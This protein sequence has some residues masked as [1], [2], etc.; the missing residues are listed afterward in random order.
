MQGIVVDLQAGLQAAGP[1]RHH[2]DRQAVGVDLPPDFPE[3]R[4]VLLPDGALDAQKIARFEV[5][6]Q[7]VT[8]EIVGT[9]PFPGT[10]AQVFV[11][12]ADGG[13]GG[14]PHPR[15]LAG[16]VV[17]R[18]RLQGE[19]A[20]QVGRRNPNALH[21]R[22]GAVVGAGKLSI[23]YEVGQPLEE[24]QQLPAP[25]D[26]PVL[27]GR[28][29]PIM[30]H[31]VR[32]AGI[33]KGV[34][35]DVAGENIR[36]RAAQPEE[37]FRPGPQFVVGV[38]DGEQVIVVVLDHH[39]V[40][41]VQEVAVREKVQPRYAV[42]EGVGGISGQQG[43]E[44]IVGTV[45]GFLYPGQKILGERPGVGSEYLPGRDRRGIRHVEAGAAQRGQGQPVGVRPSECIVGF[46][47]GVVQRQDPADL[48][49]VA[50]ADQQR[51]HRGFYRPSLIVAAGGGAVAVVPR[52][53]FEKQE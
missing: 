35:R 3:R 14:V 40:G 25:L 11:R 43:G 45:D 49:Q 24:L 32:D 34:Q 26:L 30:A 44:G 41:G 9:V 36:I 22:A 47:A 1:Q 19:A 2:V 38:D 53:A 5:V 29:D 27:D 48:L 37:F 39:R 33:G 10:E 6:L 8:D 15:Q 46:H 42:G 17:V 12:A 4:L 7:G 28:A 52:P 23:R 18:N 31:L 51:A 50:A 13:Q 16:I 20:V 21:R